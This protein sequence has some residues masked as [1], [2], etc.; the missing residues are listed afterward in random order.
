MIIW[1]RAL[2]LGFVS[3]LIPFVAA[4]PLFPIKASNAALYSTLLNLIGLAN[5]AWL[6]GVYFRH[7]KIAFTR[8]SHHRYALDCD[9][10]CARRAILLRP[11]AYERFAILV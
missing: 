1:K 10:S 2:A 5:L 4:F 9:E 7:R 6:L 8:G 11:A 3:W